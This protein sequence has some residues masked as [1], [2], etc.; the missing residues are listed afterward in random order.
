MGPTHLVRVFDGELTQLSTGLLR[1]GGLAER[2][3]ALSLESLDRLDV[4]AARRA[5]ETD[6]QVDAYEASIT[7][8]ATRMLAVRQPL[9]GDLRAVMGSLKL[10]ADLERVADYAAN[11][12]KRTLAL[13]AAPR[14][15]PVQGVPRMG[16]MV[17]G[18]VKDILDALAREDVELAL[19]VW[20]ADGAVDELYNSLFRE[21]LDTMRSDPRVIGSCTHLLFV[22]KNLE[23]VGDHA[24]NMAEEIHFIVRGSRLDMDRPKSD[25]TPSLT[26][27]PDPAGHNE[28]QDR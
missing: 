2:Q 12:A 16:Q 1:M 10:A 9:A 13:A 27:E 11:I 19:D 21:L 8:Q 7:E 26:L 5:I 17:L 15:H 25:I 23:R 6:R 20:H 18:M 3:L 22:A 24:T 14:L 4:D 28:D